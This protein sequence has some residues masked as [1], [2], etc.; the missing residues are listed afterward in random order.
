MPRHG[1]YELVY[2]RKREV[3]FKT[4]F[5]EVSEVDAH[6]PLV[7]FPLYEDWIGESVR[8]ERLLEEVSSKQPIDLI[9]ES[10]TL[11]IHL[12]WLLLHWL[13]PEVGGGVGGR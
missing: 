3:V 2:L 9:T 1:L 5:I 11:L 13:D 6:S 10:F 12:P 8:V 4:S 7:A